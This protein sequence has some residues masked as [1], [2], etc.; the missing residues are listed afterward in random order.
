MVGIR[1]IEGPVVEFVV[2]NEEEWSRT[3]YAYL[4]VPFIQG[5]TTHVSLWDRV[6]RA[7]TTQLAFPTRHIPLE[8]NAIVYKHNARPRSNEDPLR[9]LALELERAG[10]DELVVAENEEQTAE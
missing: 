10:V 5:Q 2:R 6:L 8:D 1:A 3:D 7:A 9:F 4:S